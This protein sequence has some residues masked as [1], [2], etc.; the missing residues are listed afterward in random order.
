MAHLFFAASIQRHIETPERDVDARTLGDALETVFGE[1]PRLRGYILDDQ[2]A[3]RKHLA[4][5]ID[6]RPVRDRQHLS[7]ALD[8]ASRVYVV[9]ALSGG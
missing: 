9:Q 3:L 4:V 7:D 6:G 5:F 2:G 8:A 1:Q